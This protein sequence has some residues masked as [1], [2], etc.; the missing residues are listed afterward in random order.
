VEDEGKG[1]SEGDETTKHA[2]QRSSGGP[3]RRV[4]QLVGGKPHAKSQKRILRE[5]E[6]STEDLDADLAALGAV[7]DTVRS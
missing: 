4:G 3:S 1:A 5:T 2:S 6:L 7:Q